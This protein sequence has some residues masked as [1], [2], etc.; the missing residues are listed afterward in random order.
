[1]FR[2]LLS[3]LGGMVLAAGCAMAQGS[4]ASVSAGAVKSSDGVAYPHLQH[5][6][7]IPGPMREFRAAWVATVANID[8]PSRAGLSTAEQQ[9]EAIAILDRCAELNMNAVVWQGRPHCDALYASDLEPWS[10]Y[11]TGEQGKAP[12][13]YYD[14]LEFW[15]EEAHDRG[16]EL[17]VWFNPYRAHHTAAKGELAENSIV[18]A[19][20]EMA[21]ELKNGM[22]W[23]DPARQDVQDH[24]YAVML[25]VVKRYDVDGIHMDDYFYPYTS[26]NGGADFPDDV[27]WAAYQ[28]AGGTLSRGDWRRKAVDDFVERLYRGIKAERRE[29]KFGLSPF[30]IW[31]P[32][33]PPSIQGLDQYDVLYADALKWF[34]EGWVDYYTPQLYWP[35]NQI[36]QSFPVLL[37]WWDAQNAHGRNLWPG[38]GTFKVSDEGP[39]TKDEVFNEIM[40]SRAIVPEGPGQVHFSMK[41]FMGADG[42]DGINTMLTEGPYANPALVPPSPWLDAEAPAAP[43]VETTR[44]GD[45]LAISW[46]APADAFVNVVYWEQGGRWRHAIVPRGTSVHRVQTAGKVT[47]TETSNQGLDVKEIEEDARAVTRVAVSSVDRTGNES[48]RTIVEVK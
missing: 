37:A 13:P 16:M 5:D 12:D 7:G 41:I 25:D 10:Y 21:V 36:P 20:P 31:R 44:S 46:K 14:P 9:A 4:S 38:L 18:K 15:I 42:K 34:A 47:R 19:R 45:D 29:V 6:D 28:A 32:G 39:M 43:T 27:S 1:M 22:W 24:S 40:I 2:K 30:G 23:M 26:Y 3:L 33:N 11:L 35:T 17:H 8:W 48:A